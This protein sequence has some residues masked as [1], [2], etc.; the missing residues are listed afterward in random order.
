M[1]ECCDELVV[2]HH[3]ELGPFLEKQREETLL[4]YLQMLLVMEPKLIVYFLDELEPFLEKQRE[5]ILLLYLQ[6]LLLME[7]DLEL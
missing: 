5:W 3:A 6:K 1:S 2:E 4:L 7:L